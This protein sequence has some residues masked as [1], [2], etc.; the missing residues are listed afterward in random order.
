MFSGAQS[1]RARV[2][3]ERQPFCRDGCHE[4]KRRLTRLHQDDCLLVSIST[5][6]RKMRRLCDIYTK[7]NC[8]ENHLSNCIR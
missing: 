5:H 6:E 3:Q 8:S 4:F 1:D 7:N 2:P